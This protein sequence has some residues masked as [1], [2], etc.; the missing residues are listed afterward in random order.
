MKP[1]LT[2]LLLLAIVWGCSG[3]ALLAAGVVGGVIA[4]DCDVHGGCYWDRD[5]HHYRD[6][7]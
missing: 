3:C 6:H 2:V 5:H 7:P 1:M 4:H